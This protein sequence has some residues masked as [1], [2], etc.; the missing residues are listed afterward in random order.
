M[1]KSSLCMLGSLAM[2]SVVA[3]TSS[4]E[5][6]STYVYDFGDNVGSSNTA[7]SSDGWAGTGI[8]RWITSNAVLGGTAD[9]YARNGIGDNLDSTIFRANDGDFSFAITSDVTA[10]S[11]EIIAR[12]PGFWE[13]GISDGTSALLGIGGDFGNND[14]FYIY[15]RFARINEATANASGDVAWNTLRVDFDV[16]NGT[17]DLSLNGSTLIDDAAMTLTQAQLLGADSLRIR[18]TT[19]FSGPARITLT[20]TSVPEPSSLALLGLGGLLIARR[21]R[22]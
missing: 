1:L 19:R 18:S 15:D 9:L 16:I 5:V 4:A 22:A 17:A 20:V 3:T 12:T 2:F 6:V 10:V 8:E 11:L 21:R 14:K 13:A 7:L